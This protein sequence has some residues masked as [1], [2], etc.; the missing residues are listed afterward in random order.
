MKNLPVVSVSCQSVRPA[1]EVEKPVK[2]DLLAFST[3]FL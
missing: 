3:K 2:T 1:N